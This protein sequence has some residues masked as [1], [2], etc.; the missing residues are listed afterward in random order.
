M[1]KLTITEI[2]EDFQTFNQVVVTLCNMRKFGE[3]LRYQK[4]D[5]AQPYYSLASVIN[6]YVVH[7][8]ACLHHVYVAV[9]R[10]RENIIHH[11]NALMDH[12][13]W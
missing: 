3:V 13:C 9:Y 12:I 5:A 7:I 8:I 6:L 1:L 2:G 4:L 10:A 11:R